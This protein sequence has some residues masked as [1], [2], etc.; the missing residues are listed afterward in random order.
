MQNRLLFSIPNSVMFCDERAKIVNF[1]IDL[2]KMGQFG[3]SA[4]KYIED[5]GNL[6][7]QGAKPPEALGICIIFLRNPPFLGVKIF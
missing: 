7:V 6:G 3:L 2:P 5:F 1:H 4:L